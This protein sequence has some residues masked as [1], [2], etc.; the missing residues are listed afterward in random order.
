MQILGSG[1]FGAVYKALDT[2]SDQMVAIKKMKSRRQHRQDPALLPEVRALTKLKHPFIVR[3]LEVVRESS[4]LYMIFEVLEEDLSK[5][6][7]RRKG[8]PLTEDEVR[9]LSFQILTG[10]E[11]VHQ[12]GFFHRDLKPENVL[13]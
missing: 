11:H 7:R 2:A 1:A 10:L 9:N 6:L 12:N 13:M 3:L 4:A 8:N 5:M